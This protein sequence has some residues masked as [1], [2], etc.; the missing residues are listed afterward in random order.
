M[1]YSHSSFET[2]HIMIV[3]DFIFNI[4]ILQIIILDLPIPF[5]H[6]KY[7]NLIYQSIPSLFLPFDSLAISL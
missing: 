6:M 2:D 4:I 3:R 7:R 5:F 1:Q